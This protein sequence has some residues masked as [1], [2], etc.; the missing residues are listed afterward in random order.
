M[1][2]EDVLLLLPDDAL[3][4]LDEA[5][6][7][8]VRTHLRGCAAC[9]AEAARL[10]EGLTSFASTLE[11]QPPPE[12]EDRIMAVLRE[13]WAETTGGSSGGRGSWV[14]WLSVAA[15]V[16]ALA[17]AVAWGSVS[18]VRAGRLSE[19][20]AAY[21]SFLT[22]LG[23]KDVRVGRLVP[24]GDSSVAGSAVL[25]DGEWE[26]SW[27]LVLIKAPGYTGELTPTLTSP[28]GHPI[29]MFPAKIESDG[30][31]SSWLVS[32]GDLHGYGTI[33]VTDESGAV[34][35]RARLAATD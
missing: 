21:H 14:R 11:A 34:V 16:V 18:Q 9:R 13:E 23:G 24:V 17:G 33:T 31:G 27:A 25:Y 30:E 1:R 15:I 26:R 4:T 8:Q 6:R 10:D 29:A 19:D 3:G 2:C 22:T 5:D 12:L 35:A 28:T 32:S 7:R 20:A